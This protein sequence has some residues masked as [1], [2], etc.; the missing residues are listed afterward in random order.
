[1]AARLNCPSWLSWLGGS[2]LT[3]AIVQA[4]KLAEW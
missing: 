3:T 2:G 4:A 1:M